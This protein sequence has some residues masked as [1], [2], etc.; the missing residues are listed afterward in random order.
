MLFHRQSN[1][2]RRIFVEQEII[3]GFIAHHGVRGM[4]WGVRKRSSSKP[5]TSDF[6]KT[7]HLRGKPTHQLTNKQLKLVNERLN[8]EQNYARMNPSTVERGRKTAKNILE[9]GGMA[10]AAYG[11]V[12]SPPGQ[13]LVKLGKKFMEKKAA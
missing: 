11:L 8:L 4:K 12:K 9:V 2:R 13:H 7:K 6:K 1:F 10:V 5:E 3:D